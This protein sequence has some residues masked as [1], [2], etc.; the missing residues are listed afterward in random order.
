MAE[1]PSPREQ[2]PE[3]K[4]PIVDGDTRWRVAQSGLTESALNENTGH[5]GAGVVSRR[6]QLDVMYGPGNWQL[7]PQAGN[8]LGGVELFEVHV[9]A[10]GDEQLALYN[11]LAPGPPDLSGYGHSEGE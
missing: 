1:V 9:N 3:E 5:S 10:A 6:D 4:Y 2:S 7:A 8:Q 11:Q